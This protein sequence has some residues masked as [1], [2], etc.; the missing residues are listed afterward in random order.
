MAPPKA[1]LSKNGA[2]PVP[3][4]CC[5]SI[6]ILSACA[7]LLF[8]MP[9]ANAGLLY[10]LF[11]ERFLVSREIASWPLIIATL[12]TNFMGVFRDTGGSYDNLY[13]LCG[14]IDLIAA[15]LLLTP[16]CV[17]AKRKEASHGGNCQG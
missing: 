9:E 8:M 17:R 6:P 2:L 5:W 1:S 7:T 16:A 4:D 14:G 11:M 13:R 3:M 10:V 12:M 15:L